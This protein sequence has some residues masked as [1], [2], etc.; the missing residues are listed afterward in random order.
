VAII[1]TEKYGSVTRGMLY[2]I[3]L[4]SRDVTVSTGSTVS[5]THNR[6]TLIMKGRALKPSH[7]NSTIICNIP[8]TQSKADEHKKHNKQ[9][10]DE[11]D[12]E[13]HEMSFQALKQNS[14]TPSWY[15]F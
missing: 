15:C 2:C 3:N 8:R 6:T 14:Y 7:P 5:T 13:I 1:N 4:I 11:K 9:K 12:Q 10:R